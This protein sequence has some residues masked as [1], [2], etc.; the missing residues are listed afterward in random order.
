MDESLLFWLGWLQF[1]G[2]ARQKPETGNRKPATL[3]SI[4]RADWCVR[5]KAGPGLRLTS[6]GVPGWIAHSPAHSPAHSLTRSLPA[7]TLTHSPILSPAQ[8][9]THSLARP[10]THTRS[11]TALGSR[12]PRGDYHH[13]HPPPHPPPH[14]PHRRPRWDWLGLRLHLAGL[15]PDALVPRPARSRRRCSDFDIDFT[16][17]SPRPLPPR[18]LHRSVIRADRLGTLSAILVRPNR[19]LHRAPH[20]LG[21]SS[22][23]CCP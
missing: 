20:A 1:G 3:A 23:L 19:R 17:L 13:T 15:D 16:H 9:P 6:L 21:I 8:A 2:H 4:A 11:L 18:P 10:P 14:T 7:H 22:H 12:H 5:F